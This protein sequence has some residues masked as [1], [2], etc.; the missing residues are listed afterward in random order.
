M[1]GLRLFQ[2]PL[3][4]FHASHLQITFEKVI[5]LKNGQKGSNFHV[6]QAKVPQWNTELLTF[7]LMGVT[8]LL[9]HT[10]VRYLKKL[11]GTTTKKTRQFLRSF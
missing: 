3:F 11:T 2:G 7:I 10:V 4:I 1:A 9:R 6:L 8:I 5:F